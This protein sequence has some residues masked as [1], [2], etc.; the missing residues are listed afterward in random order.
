MDR[1]KMDLFEA[2]ASLSPLASAERGV[3]C[4]LVVVGSAAKMFS[5]QWSTSV[6]ISHIVVYLM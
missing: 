3:G 5:E 6:V 4:P 1:M 2:Y